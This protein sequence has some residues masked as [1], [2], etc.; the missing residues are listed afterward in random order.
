MNESINQSINQ[1]QNNKVSVRRIYIFIL[2]KFFF[3]ILNLGR[4]EKFYTESTFQSKCWDINLKPRGY[5]CDVTLLTSAWFCCGYFWKSTCC[6]SVCIFLPVYGFSMCIF[7]CVYV[8]LR[9]KQHGI[10]V[11]HLSHESGWGVTLYLWHIFCTSL[12]MPAWWQISL[13]ACHLLTDRRRE[14]DG[15]TVKERERE[16]EREREKER[17]STTNTSL[18]LANQKPASEL[19]V[20]ALFKRVPRLMMSKLVKDCVLVCVYVCSCV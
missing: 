12:M 9:L 15:G 2:W 3:L 7:V 16:R 4:N 18:F 11:Q 1:D 17:K 10:G 5:T 14:R 13:H 19:C 8:N 6:G 20:A